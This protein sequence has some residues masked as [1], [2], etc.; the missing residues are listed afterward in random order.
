MDRMNFDRRAD[1]TI[2]KKRRVFYG[3]WMVL[4]GALINLFLGGTFFYGFTAFVGPIIDEFGWTYAM[5]SVAFSLRSVEEGLAAPLVGFLVDRFGPRKLLLPGMIAMGLGSVLLSR[6]SSLWTFYAYFAIIILAFSFTGGPALFAPIA[7]WFK[8]RVSL[9]MGLLVCGYGASGVMTPLIVWLISVCQWRT[10]LVMAGV[11]VWGLGIPLALLMRH[12]PEPYGYS[13]DGEPPGVESVNAADTERMAAEIAV[14]SRDDAGDFTWREAVRTRAFW[15]I[16][17]ALACQWMPITAMLVYIIPHLTEVGISREIAGSAVA[18][19]TFI[20]ISGRLGFGWLGDRMDRRYVLAITFSLQFIG[21]IIFANISEVWHLIPF[22][23]V[24][25]PAYGGAIPVRF[26]LQ[27]HYFGASAF[28][29]I[30]GLT[31]IFFVL[32][33]VPSPIIAGW[34]RDMLGSFRP[35]FLILS[36]PLF[37]AIPLILAAKR[38]TKP[39]SSAPR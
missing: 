13:P 39:A 9:A 7:H 1:V 35:A 23:I 31:S 29:T 26:A 5:V 18:L 21:V 27:S 11:M 22:L 30:M 15:L 24:F 36:I 6:T 19:L 4:A 10:T 34:L 2:R 14:D 12:K 28:G 17:I 38:P 20:S 8:K 33:G 16:G 3:W 37:L 32:E 25:A